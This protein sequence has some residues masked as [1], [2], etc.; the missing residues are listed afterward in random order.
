MK[1][2]PFYFN[3]LPALEKNIYKKLEEGIGQCETQ[4]RVMGTSAQVKKILP[5]VFLDNPQFFYVD[6]TQFS[7]VGSPVSC[8]VSLGYHKSRAEI[9]SMS[10]RLARIEARFLEEIRRKQMGNLLCI[11][12]AHDFIIRNT[13]YAHENLAS[14]V[15]YG[16]VSGITGVLFQKKAVCMGIAMTMKWLMDRAGIPS[17][18]VE[19][20]LLERGESP[21]PDYRG[22]PDRND[23]AW[24]L[25]CLNDIWHCM[26]VTMDLGGSS[27]DFIGYDYFL[28]S[29]K[30]MDVYLQHPPYLVDCTRETGSYFIRNR[31]V[32]TQEKEI[33]NYIRHCVQ[34][35]KKRIYFTLDQSAACLP[36]EKVQRIIQKNIPCAYN[37]RCN[38]RMAVY[39]IS[40]QVTR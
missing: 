35:R 11:K 25:V 38:D 34:G 29:E 8:S 27:G 23:H 9:R 28:R 21:S 10:E 13:S 30:H 40:L 39:D 7:V 3:Y 31:A 16:D 12:Y 24:N 26:D 36:Q 14:Q 5:M 33:E 15:V 22:Q 32:F 18:V 37:L 19:G 1:S 4:I 2:I 6:T 20:H 17:A